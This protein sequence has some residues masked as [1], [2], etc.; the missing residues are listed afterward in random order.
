M[1]EQLFNSLI[2]T[3]LGV[4]H[5]PRA[6]RWRNWCG[7]SSMPMRLRNVFLINNAT[8]CGCFALPSMLTN[9]RSGRRR[10]ILGAMLSRYS[11][12]ILAS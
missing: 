6:L 9:S 5:D 3:G 11:S 2:C 7:V 8:L 1:A 10:M 12:S 4:E